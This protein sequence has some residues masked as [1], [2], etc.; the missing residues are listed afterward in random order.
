MPANSRRI[1]ATQSIHIVK[2]A[3]APARYVYE[4]LTDYRSDD[5]RLS[6]SRPRYRVLRLAKNRVI[7]IR[8]SRA[9]GS[10]PPIAV[11]FVRL[12][13][14]NAWHT[15]QIDEADLASVDYRVIPLGRTRAKIDLR[16][17]ERWMTPKF[18]TST[19][20]HRSTAAYW[21]QIVRALE[22]SYRSGKPAT[23]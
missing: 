11:D 17:T 22:E 3:R 4:W 10:T 21:D 16:I 15:D 2:V 18:P 13:P 9:K 6:S 1:Y 19:E 5:G 8:I 23:G 7:R 12:S 14:P 20:Y